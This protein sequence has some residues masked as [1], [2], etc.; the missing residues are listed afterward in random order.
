MLSVFFSEIHEIVLV[1]TNYVKHYASTIDLTRD[2]GFF[3]PSSPKQK[4]R[5]KEHLIKRYNLSKPRRASAV[6]NLSLPNVVKGK[7]GPDF[8]ISNYNILKNKKY[9]VKLQAGSFHLNGHIVGFRPQTQKLQ[10]PFKTPSSTLP[11]KGLKKLN[12]SRQPI[13]GTLIKSCS[14]LNCANDV[15]IECCFT[16]VFCFLGIHFFYPR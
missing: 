4:G 14:D 11:V 1:M 16:K 10:S 8:Q 6:L 9:H 2:L 12:Q 7:F 3:S 5:K 15:E 13:P